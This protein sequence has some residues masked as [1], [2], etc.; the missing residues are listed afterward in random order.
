MTL[1]FLFILIFVNCN[2]L[3][4]NLNNE[5]L[6]EFDYVLEYNYW[7]N[8]LKKLDN[9]YLFLNSKN[10]GYSL[11]VK[12]FNGENFRM[13]FG[14]KGKLVSVTEIRKDDFFKAETIDVGMDYQL[15]SHR[16]WSYKDFNLA[17]VKDTI[18]LSNK[19]DVYRYF[20]KKKE[21]SGTYFSILPIKEFSYSHMVN[22]EFFKVN[23]RIDNVPNGIALFYY[24]IDENGNY[25]EGLSRL[26]NFQ[27][28]Q[29]FIKIKL[30]PEDLDLKLRE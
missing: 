5:I 22:K 4:Q 16:T 15:V 13:W 14:I 3:S 2:L 1:R 10:Q 27:K 12:E 11:T 30:K 6:F 18:L 19:H 17:V 25:N 7:D 29:K 20:R 8:D 26:A 24:Y 23:N 9:Y 21:N 28:H